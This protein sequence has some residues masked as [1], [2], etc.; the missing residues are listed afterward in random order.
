MVQSLE[1]KPHTKFHRWNV[2]MFCGLILLHIQTPESSV[3]MP[4]RFSSP[5]RQSEWISRAFWLCSRGPDDMVHRGLLCVVATIVTISVV[6]PETDS[7]HSQWYWL[8]RWRRRRDSCCEKNGKRSQLPSVP[9]AA[10]VGG[11]FVVV[12]PLLAS[13]VELWVAAASWVAKRNLIYVNLL[14]FGITFSTPLPPER[15]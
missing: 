2:T 12:V 6:S 5:L 1:T 4:K 3:Q 9:C 15:K 7:A 14:N 10:A 8:N 13:A 11:F